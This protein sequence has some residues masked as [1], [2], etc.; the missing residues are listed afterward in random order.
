MLAIDSKRSVSSTFAAFELVIYDKLMLNREIHNTA[1][2]KKLLASI[3]TDDASIKTFQN[4]VDAVHSAMGDDNPYM[5]ELSTL[6]DEINNSPDPMLLI[7]QITEEQR[8]GGLR[9]ETSLDNS[10][11][12][13]TEPLT[14]TELYG[15]AE[16]YAEIYE[17]GPEDIGNIEAYFNQEMKFS[18]MRKGQQKL[19]ELL[20]TIPEDWNVEFPNLREGA[21]WSELKMHLEME[22]IVDNVVSAAELN[23][24]VGERR[25]FKT[26]QD[27][28]PG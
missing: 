18:D 23:S 17:L 19:V 8:T 11:F 26:L 10:F 1:A 27:F 21:R 2:V 28:K 22:L 6:V 25:L 15:S 3:H 9:T 5:V 4:Y 13:Q 20:R 14:E 12:E 7:T 24:F 16:P